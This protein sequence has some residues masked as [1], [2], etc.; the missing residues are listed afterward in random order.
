MNRYRLT[1][2]ALALLSLTASADVYKCRQPDGTS[3]ISNNPCSDGSKTVK[4]VAIDTVSEANRE[5]AEKNADR[6]EEYADKLE[7]RRLAQEEAERKE[8]ERLAAIAA[9]TPVTIVQPAS[10]PPPG[11]YGGPTYIL[12]PSRY[13]Q[14]RPQ[15]QLQP[16]PNPII[17]APIEP[18]LITPST[19]P[20]NIYQV[21]GKYQS[22]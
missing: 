10:P 3:V 8:R 16:Q 18:V 11:Y 20:A 1:A 17:P 15:P 19:K 9:T 2:I 5:Q 14:P 7:A 12:P 22:R 4:T 21:P 13:P 6:L